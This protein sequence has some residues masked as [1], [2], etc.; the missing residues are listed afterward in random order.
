MFS[1]LDGFVCGVTKNPPS[2]EATKAVIDYAFEA[3]SVMELLVGTI[4]KSGGSQ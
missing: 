4:P 2:Q 1:R 3:L